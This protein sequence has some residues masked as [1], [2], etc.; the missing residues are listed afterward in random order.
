MC[1]ESYDAV[2]ERKKSHCPNLVRDESDPA[3]FSSSGM[4]P[5]HITYEQTRHSFTDWHASVSDFW[6]DWIRNYYDS[7]EP[8]LFVRFEDLLFHGEDMMYKIAECVGLEGT[9]HIG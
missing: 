1:K 7:D 9:F 3:G 4:Y 6:S 8:R 5:V 2:W